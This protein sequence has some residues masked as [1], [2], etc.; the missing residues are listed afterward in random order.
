MEELTMTERSKM[1]GKKWRE[2]PESEKDIYYE[3][4]REAREKYQKDLEEWKEKYPEAL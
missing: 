3:E 2:T 4:N 1:L